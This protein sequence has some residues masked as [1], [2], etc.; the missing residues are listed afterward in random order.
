MTIREALPS[1]IQ[2]GFTY[3]KALGNNTQ[4]FPDDWIRV[5]W[6]KDCLIDKMIYSCD[7]KDLDSIPDKVLD[8]EF[9][10]QSNWLIGCNL[11]VDFI[12]NRDI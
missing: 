7:Y 5:Y 6:G 12:L 3:H 1:V 10:L 9:D 4:L 8:L 2:N 11:S